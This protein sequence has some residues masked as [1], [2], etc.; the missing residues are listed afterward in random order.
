MSR[1]TWTKGDLHISYGRPSITP[2]YNNDDTER[3]VKSMDDV[4]YFYYGI[5]ILHHNK[6]TL[7]M[8]THDFPKVQNLPI[9]IDQIMSYNM[10]NGYVVEDYEDGGFHRRIRYAHVI[11]EDSFGFDIEYFYKIERYDYVVKQSSENNYKEWT[12]YILTIGEMEPHR[13]YGGANRENFGKVIMIKYISP[14]ELISLKNTALSF[15]EEAIRIH[16]KYSS[17]KE[18]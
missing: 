16:K 4:M 14:E 1:R 11:L 13:K 10:D 15:C 7:S 5:E 6:I 18:E 9:Y 12:E 2:F 8:S 3:E 17:H